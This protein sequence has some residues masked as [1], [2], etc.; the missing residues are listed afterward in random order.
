MKKRHCSY[1][2]KMQLAIANVWIVSLPIPLFSMEAGQPPSSETPATESASVA[3]QQPIDVVASAAQG[4]ET[5][6]PIE[7]IGTQGNWVK[8]R[9]WL[10]KTHETTNE[11]QELVAQT[12]QVRK[13]FID[14]FN[15]IDAI[16]DK[17]YQDLSLGDGK[18]QGLFDNIKRYLEK[19]QKKE[20]ALLEASSTGKSDQFLQEKIENIGRSI[21]PLKDQLA[22]L[23]LDMK[24]I[25]DL[26]KS[27]VDRIKRFD[28]QMA[29]LQEGATTAKSVANQM[30][31][32]LDH[33]KAR[34][35]YYNLKL[36]VLEKA[37]AANAYLKEDLFKDFG[38]VIETIKTQIT[39]TQDQIKKLE[40]DGLIIKDR[41][42]RVKE[43][44]LEQES[45]EKTETEKKDLQNESQKKL[46]APVE[47]SGSGWQAKIYNFFSGIKKHSLDFIVQLKNKIQKTKQSTPASPQTTTPTQA[48]VHAEPARSGFFSGIKQYSLDLV[49]SLKN[50]IFKAAPSK[51]ATP[52]QQPS[53]PAQAIAIPPMQPATN[54][55]P[56]PPAS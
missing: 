4:P 28:E 25:E 53:P 36:S 29:I 8:K 21:K 3:Q 33:N 35:Q 5:V 6:E 40:A 30:W 20:R 49:S 52:P 27:L 11:I 41:A 44:K 18:I 17:Y 10:I 9:E 26:G 42:Q 31:D 46:A 22:Q 13:K 19:K 55:V 16:L 24:S 45:K 38:S 14:A 2:K 51:P 34:E 43:L 37:K 32:I 23:K 1:S 50:K 56:V 54:V 12:E 7:K 47:E 39:R 48:P 15:D